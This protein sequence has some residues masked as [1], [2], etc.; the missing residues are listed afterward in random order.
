MV[1]AALESQPVRVA[2]WWQGAKK[3]PSTNS[4]S[5]ITCWDDSLAKPGAGDIATTGTWDG[6]PIGLT[7]AVGKDYNHAKVGVVTATSSHS[8]I[9]GDMNQ[10][11]DLSGPK[12]NDSQ[13]GRGGLFFVVDDAALHDSVSALLSGE[14]A[15]K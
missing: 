14:S 10:S 9:F 11:G 1:S 6:H 15:P 8:V 4:R 2:S 5:K 3:L 12:C 7:G 13:N